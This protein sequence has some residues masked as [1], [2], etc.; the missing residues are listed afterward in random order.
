MNKIMNSNDDD[1]DNDDN[2]INYSVILC[3]E[4]ERLFPLI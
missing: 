4:D 1:S 3:S 2:E